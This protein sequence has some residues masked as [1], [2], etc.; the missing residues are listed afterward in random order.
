MLIAVVYK[1]TVMVPPDRISSRKIYSLQKQT[2]TTPIW[3]IQMDLSI[4]I[5]VYHPE[6]VAYSSAKTLDTLVL[7]WRQ[8]DHLKQ[9]VMQLR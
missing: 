2:L 7:K 5:S 6:R 4:E 1:S 3:T 8:D 9:S